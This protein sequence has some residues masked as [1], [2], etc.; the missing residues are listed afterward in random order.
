[1]IYF[2]Y[3]L[4]LCFI[5][6]SS[7]FI[8]ELMWSIVR[9]IINKIKQKRGQN[10]SYLT[11][12]R[13]SEVYSYNVEK[14]RKYILF[15]HVLYNYVS[16]NIVISKLDFAFYKTKKKSNN[17]ICFLHNHSVT[18]IVCTGFLFGSVHSDHWRSLPAVIHW[19]FKGWLSRHITWIFTSMKKTEILKPLKVLIFFLIPLSFFSLT[20][21]HIC[22]TISAKEKGKVSFPLCVM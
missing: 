6:S 1:M 5:S 18:E 4:Q 13:C 2:Y 10:Q 12:E 14:C 20:H 17:G 7:N 11:S 16:Q 19:I 8:L 3:T 15:L 9:K 21:S 22:V